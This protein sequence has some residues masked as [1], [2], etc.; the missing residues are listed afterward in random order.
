MPGDFLPGATSGTICRRVHADVRPGS[1]VVLHDNPRA[2]PATPAA[3]AD[4]LADLTADGWS[5]E[6][7]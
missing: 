5:L 1:I 6:A 2:A 7:L 4:L 3:L